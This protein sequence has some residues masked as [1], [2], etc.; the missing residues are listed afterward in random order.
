MILHLQN[1]TYSACLATLDVALDA[2]PPDSDTR[3][4]LTEAKEDL[5]RALTDFVRVEI[6]NIEEH[7]LNRLN[8]QS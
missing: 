3:R 2:L 1:S 5:T 6:E 7:F 8:R 4:R